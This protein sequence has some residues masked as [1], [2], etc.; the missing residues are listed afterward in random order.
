[1]AAAAGVPRVP[2]DA[3]AGTS[4][5]QQRHQ[6]AQLIEQYQR[7][8]AAV[9]DQHRDA[10]RR[11]QAAW[12]VYR[13][14]AGEPLVWNEPLVHHT[15]LTGG[16]RAVLIAVALVLA[17]LA[18]A[19]VVRLARRAAATFESLDEARATLPIPVLGSIPGAAPVVRPAAPRTRLQRI[20]VGCEAGIAAC[21]VW[22][23]VLAA[24]QSDFLHTLAA[25]PLSALAQA[26]PRTLRGLP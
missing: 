4:W 13:Q 14:R 24:W 17:A 12:H 10:Q 1:M 6:L 8:V 2:Q 7:E 19:A 15:T 23:V 25:D 3:A 20:T 22:L 18:A 9:E 16:R 5:S 26:A 11:E 21:M